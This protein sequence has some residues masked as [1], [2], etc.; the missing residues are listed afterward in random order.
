MCQSAKLLPIFGKGLLISLELFLELFLH[1]RRKKCR[2]NTLMSKWRRRMS[3]VEQNLTYAGLGDS[4]RILGVMYIVQSLLDNAPNNQ[5]GCIIQKGMY[6]ICKY[7]TPRTNNSPLEKC[8]F[9]I[10]YQK[11]Q[12]KSIGGL[13][14][15][16]YGIG[17]SIYMCTSL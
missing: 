8:H 5:V 10:Y 7:I 12:E 2:R 4:N 13:V 9:H 16:W 3:Y 15:S 17:Y 6:N 1:M 14:Y 11:T